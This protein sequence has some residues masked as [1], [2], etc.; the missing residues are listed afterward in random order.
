MALLSIEF[1]VLAISCAFFRGI[2]PIFA[3]RG[4]ESGGTWMQNT[5]QTLVVRT[6]LAWGALIVITNGKEVNS[7][8]SIS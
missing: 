5:F 6:V 7:S 8:I 1:Y 4:L 2:D 3:K